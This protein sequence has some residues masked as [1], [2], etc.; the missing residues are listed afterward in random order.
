VERR[1]R[2][3]CRRG[4]AEEVKLLHLKKGPDGP[5]LISTIY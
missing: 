3:R 4:M 5:F 2:R 1:T